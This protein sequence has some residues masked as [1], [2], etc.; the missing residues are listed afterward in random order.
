M[1]GRPELVTFEVPSEPSRMP[2]LYFCFQAAVLALSASSTYAADDTE[3]DLSKAP[4]KL[5]EVKIVAGRLPAEVIGVESIQ[6]DRL[7]PPFL[8]TDSMRALSGMAISESGNV[9]SLSQVRVR[10]AEADHIKV[11][12]NGHPINLLAANLN[13]ATISPV[14]ISRVD[15]LNGPRSAIL[16]HHALAGV[17][18]LTAQPLE[19]GNR[20]Y[21]ETGTN[22]TQGIGVDL[23]TK[24]R[25]APV[26]LHA[27]KRTT[28][29]TNVA[30]QG[31]ERDGF[32]QTTVHAGYAHHGDRLHTNGF[33][34]TTSS[35]SEYDPIPNDGDRHIEVDDMIAAQQL[36]WT[37]AE[38]IT[39]DANANVTQSRLSNFNAEHE[40]NSWRG[41]LIRLSIEGHM[42]LANNHDLNLLLDHTVEAF[43]Q[44]VRDRS[45]GNPNYDAS[46]SSTG[47]AAEH[48]ISSNQWQWHTSLRHE[49][50]DEFGDSTAWQVSA[51]RNHQLWSMSYAVGVGVKN[52]TFIE[53][54]GY[55]PDQFLGNPG[56]KPERSL[57]HQ[58]AIEHTGSTHTVVLSLFSSVLN[59]E[60]N[61]FEFDPMTNRFT[62][63]N[64]TSESQRQGYELRIAREFQ[65]FK[66]DAN[67]TYVDSTEGKTP[68]IRRPHHVANFNLFLNL[69][70]R[71]RSRVS[72]HYIGKQLDR[73]F[74][75]FPAKVVTLDGHTIGIT[76]IEYD[77]TDKLTLHGRVENLFDLEYEQVFG[78]RSYPRRLSI[79][80]QVR[81]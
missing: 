55:A 31:D 2:S 80:A 56:L 60:I 22:N 6:L 58:V 50:N 16:G 32:E 11:L 37:I 7:A 12:L 61:G 62:A 73:D 15:A 35:I 24:F 23:S 53:R 81:F 46:L 45:F 74:S 17:V 72:F 63:E 67:Y 39:L 59:D 27:A 51:L 40:T 36:G 42:R 4:T 48:L 3:E 79:G 30:Y 69:G 20:G 78:Y 14:G 47:V 64:L 10:G 38:D 44:R 49:L 29:G 9:G 25:N 66:M 21:V 34:R 77:L 70:Q 18:N 26:S 28:D 75:S 8:L 19:S 1:E 76:S 13:F 68:E 71:M 52:P 65:R 54:F 5:E 43:E 41:D 33:I 57:Q